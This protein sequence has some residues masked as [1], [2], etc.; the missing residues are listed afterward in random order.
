MDSLPPST[1]IDRVL[2]TEI[3][4][5]LSLY[6]TPHPL[7]PT[8]LRSASSLVFIDAAVADGQVL[9]ANVTAGSE[10]HF[11][12]PTQDAIA[13]ITNTLLG[14]KNIS[15]VQVLSHGAAGE[16][17]L[18]HG[19][20]DLANLPSYATQLQSWRSA[21]TDDA[22]LLLYG[23]NVAQ[24]ELGKAFV[25]I[26]S[27]LTGADVAASDNLTGSAAKGGDWTLEVQT[28][29]IES[30]L[31]LNQASRDAY[32][33]TLS[34]ATA[35]NFAVGAGSRAVAVGDLN[36]DGNTDIAT[37]N[38]GS[39]NVSVL[40]GD[41]TGSF[42]TATNFSVGSNLFALA[43]GDLNGDGNADIATANYFSNT[44]SVLLGD[45]TGSFGTATNF[46]VG[47]NPASVAIGDFNG[48]G[49]LDIAS[50]NSGSNNVS[51]LLGTGTGSFGTATNF[52]VSSD[53]YSVAIGDLNGDGKLDIVTANYSTRNVSVLLGDGTGSFG[54]A[55]NFGTDAGSYAVA[56]GDL[57]GDGKLDIAT[58]NNASSTVSVL[59]GTGTGSFGTATNF[60]VGSYPYSVAIG[61][62]NGDGKADIAT[63]NYLSDDVSV[64]FGTETGNFGTATNFSAGS[65]SNSLAIGDFNG[66]GKAD[67][68]TANLGSNNVSVL[69]N[70]SPTV[71]V[72][73]GTAPSETGTR[74]TFTL[75]LD[76]PAPT[77]GLT[78]N[79]TPSGTATNPADYSFTAGSNITSVSATSIV[80][81][82]GA[83][84]AT[85]NVV[86]VADEVTDPSETVILTLASGNDYFLGSNATAQF[87]TATNFSVGTAP[88]SVAIGDFNGD[89][90]LDIATANS[91]SSNVSVLL[92]DGTGR[93]GNATN[94]TAGRPYSIGSGDFNGDG[95]ADIATANYSS[96]TVSVLLGDGTGGFGN[97]TNF[98]VGSNPASVEI[99]D[100]NGDG[101]LDITTVNSN[102]KDVSVLLGDGTG[103]F[104]NATNFNVGPEPIFKA[105]ISG[106][107]GDFNGDGKLDIATA[108]YSDSSVS[109]LL[110]DGTGSFGASTDFTVGRPYSIAIGDFNGDGKLDIATANVS[111]NTV[112][113]LLGDGTGRFGNATNFTVGNNPF[114]IAI[115][116]F[117]GDGNA[118][119]AA[120]N[121]GSNTVSMLLG[122]GTGRFGNA[123]NFTVENSPTSVAIGDFNGDDNADIATANNGSNSVS[124]LL[125][126]PPTSA[127][128]VIADAPVVTVLVPNAIA[129]EDT[130]NSGSF[131]LT[132]A[133]DITQD[134]TVNYTISGT[135]TNGTDYTTLSGTATIS[136]GGSFVDVLVNPINDTLAEGD[137]TIQLSLA[138]GD[139]NLGNT[140]SGTV[141][142]LANDNPSDFNGDGKSD[143][144]WRNPSTGQVAI[145]EMD[146]TT[147]LAGSGFINATPDATWQ[148][149]GT[150]DFNGDG[151]ADILWRNASSYQMAVWEMDGT[152]LL[153]GSGLLSVAP[154][155][156]WQIA[157]IA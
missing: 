101:K 91:G 41:G 99:G 10:V 82:A 22:D 11:L 125:N 120:A 69:L 104:G 90:K 102:S 54:T 130:P 76:Q 65:G 79:F 141:T 30:G 105:P 113:V 73:A 80:I 52:S 78:V 7:Q 24:G 87:A 6:P 88:R 132:R 1:A 5:S 62:F 83:T 81:A 57:N 156:T 134:L 110:G 58:A 26:L 157:G 106:A 70:T 153:A 89:G 114:F 43:I 9:A 16:L 50:A 116:D 93:F 68:A 119:I 18:G 140:T 32:T 67:I 21:L 56:I 85:L 98:N 51:V 53:A 63:A 103:S 97:A 20:L 96:N 122:E 38:T 47:S 136:A 25:Q 118:D 145:W 17:Q 150:G 121:S 64:L 40:L 55:T 147:L 112:S 94:F 72:A 142:I 27:Q 144:L 14:R 111:S 34:F 12:D 109:V 139:Y 29:R 19:W 44:V 137:E 135:A 117:N 36:G 133:G 84:T 152:T 128:L 28:G 45:G 75:T 107:I 115:G 146:G 86:P 60:S 37:A 154:D 131:R 100:F 61:D 74:G 2:S 148:I 49:K 138:A 108:N 155:A 77:G 149:A 151:K 42:G 46:S 129:S 31:A 4:P 33:D 48:D 127:F 66:D 8:P 123:T 126:N 71:T 59:L 95:N 13:Q 3:E 124:V 39:S 92:G 15:S 35:T 143:I 23:C